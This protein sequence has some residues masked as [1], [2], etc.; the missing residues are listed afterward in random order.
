MTDILRKKKHLEHMS[1]ESRKV[2][3][4]SL[5]SPSLFPILKYPVKMKNGPNETKIFH[6]H[7]IFKKNEIKSAKRTPI[8]LY[9]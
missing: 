2:S 8:P 4:G 7:G 9:I 3:G 5:K 6:F 1:G